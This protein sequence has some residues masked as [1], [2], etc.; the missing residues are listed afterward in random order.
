MYVA[1]HGGL[2]A[3]RCGAS[4]RRRGSRTY[5]DGVRE[6]DLRDRD[7]TFDA[8]ADR[9]TAVHGDRRGEGQG[10][11]RQCHLPGW[12]SSTTTCASRPTC[13]RAAHAAGVAS[14]AVPRFKCIYPKHAL[15]LDSERPCWTGTLEPTNEAHAI[16]KISPDHGRAVLPPSIM[17]TAGS[18]PC[19]PTLYG[20]GDNLTCRVPTLPAMIRKF[21]DAKLGGRQ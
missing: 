11:P 13:S 20:P 18:R 19:P 2:V 3:W 8:I 4:C 16:A 14:S 21:H 17:V 7:A 12:T 5:R 15:Q 9:R 6:L 10:D 1:G